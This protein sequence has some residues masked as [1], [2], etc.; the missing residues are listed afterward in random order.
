MKLVQ[1]LSVLFLGTMMMACGNEGAKTN[2]TKELD[3]TAA[4]A[5]SAPTTKLAS[6]RIEV[7]DFY[8][9]HRCVTC[10]AIEKN[11]KYTVDTFFP[12]EQEEGKI[13]FKTVNVDKAENAKIAEE[14]QA[15]GTALFLYVVKGDKKTKIDLT[16][17]A[18]ENGRDQAVFSDELKFFIDN[19]LKSL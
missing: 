2:A 17:N 4:T 1:I 10:K 3:A 16:N 7:I 6:N 8:G 13:I 9:T 19:E 11:T 18:F 14:F 5:E 12:K 15:T